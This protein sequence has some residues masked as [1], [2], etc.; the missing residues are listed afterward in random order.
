MIYEESNIITY[1]SN[2][3]ILRNKGG[4]INIVRQMVDTQANPI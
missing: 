4:I 1:C 2:W 3:H